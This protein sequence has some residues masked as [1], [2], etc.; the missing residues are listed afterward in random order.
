MRVGAN[1]IGDLLC[2]VALQI[3]HVDVLP[4]T[5][6]DLGA[7]FDASRLIEVE[8][9]RVKLIFEGL[10]QAL[11]GFSSGR[12]RSEYLL[13]TASKWLGFRKEK[14]LPG[15][16]KR[17]DAKKDVPHEVWSTWGC[18]QEHQLRR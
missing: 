4:H 15:L 16:R 6:G 14:I 8:L 2:Q 7:V 5:Q 12:E 17:F 18:N 9:S 11:D 10:D 3:R 1:L 13:P